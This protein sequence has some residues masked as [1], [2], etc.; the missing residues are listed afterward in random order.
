MGAAGDAW[1]RKAIKNAVQPDEVLNAPPPEDEEDP[2]TLPWEDPDE[3]EAAIF[4][5]APTF[6]D[7]NYLE[8]QR[9]TVDCGEL[10]VIK[11]LKNRRVLDRRA[12]P[13]MYPVRG[14]KF[15]EHVQDKVEWERN[16]AVLPGE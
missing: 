3:S 16:L 9:C 12:R 15:L 6:W 1:I 14:L 13:V 10:K 11:I 8:W 4:P 5:L 7:R 2:A